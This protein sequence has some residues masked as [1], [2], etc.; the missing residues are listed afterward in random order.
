MI[1]SSTALAAIPAGLRDPLLEEYK[2]IVQNFMERK[3]SPSELSGGKFCEIVYTILDGHAKGTYPSKPSKPS[4]F[5]DACKKLE[6]NGK[7][8]RSFQILIPRIL[9]AL[10]EIRNNRNVGHV[11]GDVDPNHMDAQAVLSM[12]NWVMAE[13]VRVFHNVSVDDAQALVDGLVERRI[14][15]VWKG[16]EIRRV[17]HPDMRLEDQILVLMASTTG[18]V[19]VAD[20]L[21]WTDSTTTDKKKYLMKKIRALHEERKVDF[22]VD[23]AT[24]QL[25]PPGSTRAE[26]VVADYAKLT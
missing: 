24:A 18:T 9:P 8:P 14:P 21:K 6:S 25:L 26:L 5:V 1:S 10:Y 13:M 22:A 12:C 23:E 17:L 19:A 4:N 2:S 15:L 7:V 3:W 20:L 16:G 11:G